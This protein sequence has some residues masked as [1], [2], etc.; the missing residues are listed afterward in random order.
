MVNMTWGEMLVDVNAKGEID[1]RIAEEI[2]ANA[3]ATEWK[4]K[5]RAGVELRTRCRVRE[6]TVDED[7]MANGVVYYDAEGREPGKTQHLAQSDPPPSPPKH[8]Q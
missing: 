5:I 3:D 1:Y 4:F 2:S 6:I 7:G 8:Q